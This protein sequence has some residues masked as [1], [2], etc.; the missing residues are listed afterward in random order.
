[1]IYINQTI[2][3][4]GVPFVNT[5]KNKFIKHVEKHHIIEKNP[6][7]IITAN[8]EIVMHAQKDKNYLNILSS[9]DYVVL[10]GI[11]IIIASRILNDPL[12]ERIAGFDLLTEMLSLAAKHNKSVFFYG[13]HPDVIKFAANNA[14]EKYPTLNIAGYLMAIR[15]II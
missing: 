12:E 9:S 15:K 5:S 7:F 1:M 13:A 4:L 8:P 10:D 3:V 2:N 6:A 11:G 14:K